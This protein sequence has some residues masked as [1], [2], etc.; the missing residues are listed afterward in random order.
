MRSAL[1]I[2]LVVGAWAGAAFGASSPPPAGR[3]AFSAGPLAQ[4]RSNVYV[5]DLATKKTTQVTHS[6]GIEFDPTLS[7]DGKR[8]CVEVD[9]KRQRGDPRRQ[10][11]WNTPPQTDA[12][13][14][15]RLRAGVVA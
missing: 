10:R 14:R 15:A 13:S 4:G 2:A 7:P 12:E 1:V 5:Y 8:G 9:P 3:I 6:R 11:R